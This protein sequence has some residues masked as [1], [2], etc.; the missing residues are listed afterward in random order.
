MKTSYQAINQDILESL[1]S[2]ED[3]EEEIFIHMDKLD[4]LCRVRSIAESGESTI[5]RASLM[6]YS[7]LVEQEAKQL[8]RLL[9]QFFS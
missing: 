3:L 4:A 9:D 2:K 6:H 1:R 8:R 5:P 7:Q